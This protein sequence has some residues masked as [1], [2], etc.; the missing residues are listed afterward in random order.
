M[1]IGEIAYQLMISTII[2]MITTTTANKKNGTQH[3]AKTVAIM[4][5]AAT[6]LITIH[7]IL[8]E[9]RIDVLVCAIFFFNSRTFFSIFW[10][11]LP[12]EPLLL[13]IK[14]LDLR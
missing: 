13:L 9:R 10:N 1:N 12:W 4:L 5:L 3:A 14:S 11:L 8:G 7:F 2:N 6:M